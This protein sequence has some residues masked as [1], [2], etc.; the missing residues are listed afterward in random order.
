[1]I[2][3]YIIIIIVLFTKYIDGSNSI[4]LDCLDGIKHVVWRRR[5]GSQVVDLIYLHKQRIDD[6]LV[7]ELKVLVAHPVVDVAF[8]A[9]EEVVHDDHLVA[10]HHQSVD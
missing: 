4:C 5:G 1:M 8:A 10:R 2:K 7:D 3:I 6:I 9:G